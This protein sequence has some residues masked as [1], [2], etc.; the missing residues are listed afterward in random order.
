MEVR[1]EQEGTAMTAALAGELDHHAAHTALQKLDRALDAS[2]PM[3]L[4]LDLSRVTFMDS[5]GIAVVMRAHRR[6]TALGGSLTL[7]GVPAQA[8]KV[9]DAAGIS[10]RITMEE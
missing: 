1:I 6:M 5:S 3:A 8:K 2:V 4:S 9:F 10:R 7:R